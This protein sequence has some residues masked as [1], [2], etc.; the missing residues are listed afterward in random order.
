MKSSPF[1]KFLLLSILCL[2]LSLSTI[3]NSIKQANA[4]SVIGTITVG[5]GPYGAIYDPAN[6]YIYTANVFSNSVSVID[7]S[8][9]TVIATITEPAGQTPRELAFNSATGNIY[10]A[11]VYSNTVSIIDGK[12]SKLLTTIPTGGSIVDG[13]A[14]DSSNGNVYAVNAGS[15]TVSV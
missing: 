8:T 9:N 6:G 11:D 10:V 2:A 15:G 4:D 1:I 13:L 5:T 14:Y 7:G 12:T 3:I